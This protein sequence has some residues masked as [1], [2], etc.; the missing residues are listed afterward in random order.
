MTELLFNDQAIA[1]IVLT[2]MSIVVISSVCLHF[3]ADSLSDG[4]QKFLMYSIS[5]SAAM[6]VCSLAFVSQIRYRNAYES[7]WRQV[8]TND[9][10]AEITLEADDGVS[11]KAGGQLGLDYLIFEYSFDHEGKIIATDS[12][13]NKKTK[14]FKLAD[15]DPIK[16][17]G[18]LTEDSRITKV[19][20]RPVKGTYKT[21]Y[22]LQG[23]LEKASYDGEV[24]I[25]VE[26]SKE[27][28]ELDKLF[29]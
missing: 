29:N 23:P 18:D 25:T 1:A 12:S 20:Y 11:F 9:V 14:T 21:V 6:L 28:D 24:R 22:S 17:V 27:S 2:S 15:D 3:R 19:E 10:K 5:I 4:M 13:G 8:Y 7:D 26:S 16:V